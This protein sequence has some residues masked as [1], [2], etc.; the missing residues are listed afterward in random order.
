MNPNHI[1]ELPKSPVSGN[2][3]PFKPFIPPMNHCKHKLLALRNEETIHIIPSMSK[4]YTCVDCGAK[5]TIQ[6]VGLKI[7]GV[8][9]KIV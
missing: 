4:Q 5:F 2:I 9:H 1:P 8:K 7:Y 3:I 6:P